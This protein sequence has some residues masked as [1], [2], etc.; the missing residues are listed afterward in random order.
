[1]TG[2]AI[3]EAEEFWKIYKLDVVEIPTNKP[4]LRNDSTDLIYTDK[5]IKYK[6]I[7]N[8]VLERNKLGQPILIGT[9]DISKSE[10]ISNMLKRSGIKHEVLNAKQHEKEAGIV[11]QAGSIGSVT[12]ATNMAGRGTDIV[13]G[14]NPE[15]LKL[16]QD[17]QKVLT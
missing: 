3:T 9:T 6:A 4:M 10:L 1:M 12:V 13:L 8:D 15:T 5:K 14:G 11:A 16:K 2:T 17:M 7:I